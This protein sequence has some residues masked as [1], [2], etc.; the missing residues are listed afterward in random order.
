MKRVD[1]L[2]VKKRTTTDARVN[3]NEEPGSRLTELQS[4]FYR[5]ITPSL[6]FNPENPPIRQNET[7]QC[8]QR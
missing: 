8:V 3:S 1:P 6:Q 7:E 5:G 2:T 4:E